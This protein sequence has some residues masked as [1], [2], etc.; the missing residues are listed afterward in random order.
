MDPLR[1][2][3]MYAYM[4]AAPGAQ[5]GAVH[6]SRFMRAPDAHTTQGRRGTTRMLPPEGALAAAA[7]AAAALAAAALAAAAL[8]AGHTAPHR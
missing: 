1:G 6:D 2:A 8:A 3:T 4:I 5:P 7:L